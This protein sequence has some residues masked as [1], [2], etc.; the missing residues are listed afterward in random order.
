MASLNEKS[1]AEECEILEDVDGTEN[2][3]ETK[4][5]KKKNKKKKPAG[6]LAESNGPDDQ[7]TKTEVETNHVSHGEEK[8]EE[9]I[10]GN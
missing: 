9:A 6:A 3:S 2:K 1:L 4:P 5:K 8:D 10:D 7:E